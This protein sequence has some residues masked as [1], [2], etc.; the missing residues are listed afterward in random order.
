[1]RADPIIFGVIEKFEAFEYCYR[2]FDGGG[3]LSVDQLRLASAAHGIA[4]GQDGAATLR[5]A[6][7]RTIRIGVIAI[8]VRVDFERLCFVVLG[9][10]IFRLLV[11]DSDEGFAEVAT[12]L[13]LR[14]SKSGRDPVF[15]YAEICAVGVGVG[16]T[17]CVFTDAAIAIVIDL[18]RA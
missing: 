1:M 3:A 7:N 11:G 13:S 2:V 17:R 12:V 5:T 8:A 16:R 15:S 9:V 14:G 6:R 18:C 4:F 10:C